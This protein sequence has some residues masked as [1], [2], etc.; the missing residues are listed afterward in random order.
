MSSSN[1]DIYLDLVIQ[2]VLNQ[3]Y[4]NFEFIIVDDG[5][6]NPFTFTTLIH[7]MQ[8]DARIKVHLLNTRTGFVVASRNFGIMQAKGDLIAIVED[9]DVFHPERIEK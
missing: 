5:S 1:R 9:D 2:S 7:Y 3:T 8:K 4:T 6:H